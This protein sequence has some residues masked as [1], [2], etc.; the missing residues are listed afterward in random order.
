MSALA[1]SSC[2]VLSE[3]YLPVFLMRLTR[4]FITPPQSNSS[5][6]T[7]LPPSSASLHWLSLSLS[8]VC[9]STSSQSYIYHLDSWS[10]L[11]RTHTHTPT[12]FSF[13]LLISIQHG[14]AKGV[15][16]RRP[17]IGCCSICFRSTEVLSAA[18]HC[19]WRMQNETV[20]CLVFCPA[21]SPICTSWGNSRQA[22]ITVSLTWLALPQCKM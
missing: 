22:R 1:A 11:T 6:H 20:R 13:P 5:W 14:S 19:L 21:A 8:D 18:I 9:T 7:L 4:S 2:A 3:L 17:T 16:V 15:G 10:Q 12:P